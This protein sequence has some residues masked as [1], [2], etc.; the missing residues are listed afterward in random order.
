MAAIDVAEAAGGDVV[1]GEEEGGERAVGS[2]LREELV[3]D[4][5]NI[6]QAIVR[7]GALAAEIGL[8][9]GHEESCGDAFTGNVGDDE[10]ETVRAEV[11]EVVVVA[12]DGARGE[13][14]AAIVEGLDGGTELGEKAALDFVGDFELLGGAAF[15]FE[16]CGVGAALGFEGVRDFVKADEGEGVAIGVAE[17]GGDA[18]PDR[19]FFAEERGF[20]SVAHGASFGIELDAAEA[21]SV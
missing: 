9:I 3:D 6:F 16:F 2:V 13:T 11:E 21:W 5:K 7:D 1:V 19:G 14:S 10:A 18:A 4:A 8:K 15:R 17:A 20:D 12:A